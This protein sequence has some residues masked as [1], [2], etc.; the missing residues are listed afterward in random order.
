MESITNQERSKM[1]LIRPY[2]EED[3]NFICSSYIKSTYFNSIDKT[4]RM[5]KKIDHDRAMDKKIN[6]MILSSVVLVAVPE[7]DTD[8]I[9]GYIIFTYD[10]CH[11]VYV[12]NDFRMIGIAT[13]L[14]KAADIPTDSLIVS[15]LSKNFIQ[16]NNSKNITFEYNPY[17]LQY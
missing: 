6:E 2:K 8:L 11:Y 10:C 15:H 9:V 17:K 13:E 5:V 12:K 1:I 4:T 3:H 7:H 14:F 16:I